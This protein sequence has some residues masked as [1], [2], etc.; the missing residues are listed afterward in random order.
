MQEFMDRSL[1]KLV[2]EGIITEEGE[3]YYYRP[4]P[5]AEEFC[6]KMFTIYEEVARREQG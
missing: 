5:K 4:T 2:G 6:R 1:A 3:L